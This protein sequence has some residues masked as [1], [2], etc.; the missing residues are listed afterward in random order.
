MIA[1]RACQIGYHLDNDWWVVCKRF[2]KLHSYVWHGTKKYKITD[3]ID[4]FDFDDKL[5]G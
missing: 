1:V 5:L 4:W 3:D 2:N